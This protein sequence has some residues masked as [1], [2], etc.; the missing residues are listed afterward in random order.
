MIKPGDSV[1]PYRIARL[2]GRGGMGAVYL[3]R[4]ESLRRD[5]AL[6]LIRPELLVQ[7]EH[8]ERFRREC[9]ALGRL[10]H[11]NVVK[12]YENGVTDG[13]A[14]F[15]MEYV[16]GQ[17]LGDLLAPARPLPLAK[18][19]AI[20]E[21]LFS[22]LDYLHELGLLHRDI[23]PTNVQ[24]PAEGP[25]KLM[26]FGLVKDVAG[27][28]VTEEGT[29]LGTPRYMA[30]E[31]ILGHGASVASDLY[32]MGIVM[33]QMLTG[34]LPIDAPN[35]PGLLEQLRAGRYRAVRELRPDLPE[36]MERVVHGLL[37]ARP[38][39]RP[40]PAGAVWA[41]LARAFDE[42]LLTTGVPAA[43]TPRPPRL[44]K[45][46][47]PAP[48]RARSDTTGGGRG[49]GTKRAGLA[50]VVGGV[51]GLLMVA[52]ALRH[53]PAPSPSPTPTVAARQEALLEA[54]PRDHF[55]PRAVPGGFTFAAETLPGRRVTAPRG[56]AA[57]ARGR[58]FV[59]S[60]EGLSWLV[61]GRW[62]SRA[63]V[64]EPAAMAVLCA[65][66]E[67]GVW[68]R[69][70]LPAPVSGSDSWLVRAD[71][72]GV[73]ERMAVPAA[74]GRSGA[75]C[76]WDNGDLVVA[77]GEQPFRR[78]A[79]SG[80]LAP[81]A[82]DGIAGTV[83]GFFSRGAFTAEGVWLREGT[84][85]KR[86]EIGAAPG[87][88]RGASIVGG[89]LWVCGAQGAVG[90]ALDGATPP[91]RLL[92]DRVLTSA[93]ACGPDVVFVG[94]SGIFRGSQRLEVP[95]VKQAGIGMAGAGRAGE[96]WA[97]TT[98]PV[99]FARVDA[100]GVTADALE[101]PDPARTLWSAPGMCIPY[102]WI[103]DRALAA[104]RRGTLLRVP[105]GDG[106]AGPL[107][108]LTDSVWPLDLWLAREGG[109]LFMIWQREGTSNRYLDRID[110]G[111]GDRRRAE[112]LP[113]HMDGPVRSSAEGAVVYQG[114]FIPIVQ[115][116][117]SGV[118]VRYH[119]ARPTIDDMHGVRAH[120]L[121]FWDVR[122][123][124]T[125]VLPLPSDYAGGAFTFDPVHSQAVYLSRDGVVLRRKLGTSGPGA[126]VRVPLPAGADE[127][128][129]CELER[130]PDGR[131][132]AYVLQPRATGRSTL[133]VMDLE[134][135]DS[136]RIGSWAYDYAQPRW[137]PD[138]R[139][140]A[141]VRRGVD[142]GDAELAA[143]PVRR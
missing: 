94:P 110:P 13:V 39:Q 55:P 60:A 10:S 6:K 46:T 37:S 18:V 124:T 17:T 28:L 21:G 137:S 120:E 74:F 42:T 62:A 96:V 22:A 93:F 77:T 135:R 58:L 29:A 33:Y 5:V 53:P 67:G 83:L 48:E 127:R 142:R 14:W 130:S 116:L 132:L 64:P 117:E 138:G 119:G 51:A 32:Q 86:L 31:V 76:L 54:L 30:P 3:A 12:V 84:G 115:L 87:A 63:L 139:L 1:G 56:V 8:A 25:V 103:D 59:A 11:P 45:S 82:T 112:G 107:V 80:A 123:K 49:L 34:Q 122:Q 69:L 50:V 89:T 65:A 16:A 20:A 57:D 140:L 143:R 99:V 44:R 9:Q 108:A 136:R 106:P 72:S 47:R 129:V 81:L 61:D 7:A 121:R 95:G 92:S 27:T 26:D 98:T 15:A 68:L 90:V 85:W 40:Q 91:A 75:G 102:A 52:G 126:P 133:H 118:Y 4:Q 114:P 134:T 41:A 113:E 105:V 131:L 104:G 23:K 24:V 125:G 141:F 128:A 78:D 38:E 100:R 43:E 88:I 71:E 2:L 97:L 73:L 19:R 36:A 109:P 35:L 111:T 66:R 70:R 101:E 79:K